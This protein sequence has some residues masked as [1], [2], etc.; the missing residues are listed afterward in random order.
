VQT[1]F[2]MTMMILLMCESKNETTEE[3]AYR[4]YLNA[5]LMMS[6]VKVQII[7]LFVYN[8]WKT[9]LDVQKESEQ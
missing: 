8:D 1:D 9:N 6:W 5:R 3:H 7:L 2:A 4:Q